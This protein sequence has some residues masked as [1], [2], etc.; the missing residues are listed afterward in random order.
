MGAIHE[1]NESVLIRADQ[2][3]VTIPVKHVFDR[4]VLQPQAQTVA[5]VPGMARVPCVG[6][7]WEGQGGLNAGLM[8]TEDRS[9]EY[10]LIVPPRSAV[11]HPSLTHDKAK[12]YATQLVVDGRKGFT[13]AT[14]RENRLAWVNLQGEFHPDEWYWCLEQYGPHAGD[15]WAQHSLGNQFHWGK[16][17]AF[18][19]LAVSRLFLP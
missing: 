17:T 1:M 13:L 10:Y 7:Y 6:E 11:P 15:A 12:E 5:L 4:C 18:R 19:A 14:R 2:A 16:S 8:L 3:I 9:R